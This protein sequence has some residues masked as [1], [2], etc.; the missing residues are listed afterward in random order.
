MKRVLLG[1]TLLGIAAVLGGCPIYGDSN[2]GDYQVCDNTGCYD[3][4]DPNR[5]NACVG[6]SCNTSGDC[7][8]QY[9]CS[10]DGACV[11]APQQDAGDCSVGGCPTGY[12]CEVASGVAQCAPIG[13]IPFEDAGVEDAF[14]VPSYD[15]SVPA[16]DVAVIPDSASDSLLGPETSGS[17]AS[18]LDG[19]LAGEAGPLGGLCNADSQCA[20]TGAKCVDGLCTEQ[21]QLCS[22]GTQCLASGELC[23]DGLCLPTCSASVACPAGYACDFHHGVCSGNPA[24]CTSGATCTGGSVCVESHCAAPCGGLDSGAQC[25]SGQVCVNGGCIPDQQAQ[26]TCSID[27]TACSVPG[28]GTG[29]C[30][31]G[32]CYAACP[33]GGGCPVDA[34]VCKQVPGNKGMYP[35]C[36]TSSDL[37]NQCNPAVGSYCSAGVC[38]DGYCLQ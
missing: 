1:V 21:N 37:G 16:E 36:G 24:P 27:G 29:T 10:L 14:A 33:D 34:P 3:C 20:N 31:H 6:W 12:V 30:V 7:P 38:I 4:P 22:D 25:A 26:F 19:G 2:T 8:D 32:D 11:S 18:T 5:S 9:V 13:T 17:E 35:V 23:V 28:G 15:A